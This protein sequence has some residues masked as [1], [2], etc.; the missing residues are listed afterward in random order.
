[1]K[2]EFTLISAL[3][4]KF[5]RT[6]AGGRIVITAGVASLADGEREQIVHAVRVFDAFDP[7]NDPYAEHDFGA[8]EVA[9]RRLFWKIDY[10]D[11]AMRYASEDPSD[12]TNTTRVLT[13]MLADEY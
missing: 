2:R 6:F 11:A 7:D 9:S 1:M 13:I 3:N 4:D 10:Y 8:F 5:R 12:P